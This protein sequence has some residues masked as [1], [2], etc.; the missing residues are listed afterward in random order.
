MSRR[1]P[2]GGTAARLATRIA[3]VCAAAAFAGTFLTV[4]LTGPAD[5][6][7]WVFGTAMSVLVTAVVGVLAWTQAGQVGGRV[8][9]LR[10]ALSKLGRGRVE[11]RLRVSGKDE[12]AALGHEIQ[13]LAN[14]LDEVFKEIEAGAGTAATMDPAVRDF[15]DRTLG[16]AMHQPQ[17]YEVD[18]TVA[19]GTRGGLDYFG[20]VGNALYVVSAEGATSMSVLA[21]RLARDELVRALETGAPARKALAHTNRAM[22]KRLPRGA[23]AKASLLEFGDGEVKLYQAG[24]RAPLWICQAGEVLE[25]AAEGIALGLDEGPVFE[26]GLR[27]QRIPVQFGV[28]LV[29]TNDAGVRMQELLDL[30]REHSPKHTTPFMH[31]VVGQLESGA[32]PDGLR[33]DVLLAT[34]KRVS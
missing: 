19:A 8:T 21:C 10:L 34:V 31:L 22:H 2:R 7:E 28:R 27:S 30:V 1:G 5:S 32:G 20:S 23:C 13:N 25:L 14:D 29:Q 26:K 12:L 16:E 17:G 4:V 33:E 11:L 9:E 3:L 18:G 6:R 15:R 24:Y